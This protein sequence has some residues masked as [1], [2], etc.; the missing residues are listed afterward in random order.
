MKNFVKYMLLLPLFFTACETDYYE[1]F[2]VTDPED[3]MKIKPSGEV[4]VLEENLKDRIAL[5]FEWGDAADRG[6]GTELTCY[7]KMDIANNNFQTSFPKRELE[8]E[9]RSVSFTHEELNKLITGFWKKEAG[10]TVELEVE[11]IADVTVYPVYMKP[12]VSKTM[13]TVTSYV[14]AP[15]NLYLTGSAIKSEDPAKAV[16]LNVLS[17]NKEY[18]WKGHLDAG[19]FK[20][21]Q[22]RNEMLPS[23]NKGQDR[24]ALFYR[25]SDSDPDDLFTVDQDGIHSIY[26]N[27]EEMKIAC[28]PLPY[29]NVWMVGHATPA[30]WDIDNPILMAWDPQTPELFIYE[31]PL[32]AGEIKL[33]LAKGDWGCDYLMPVENGAGIDDNRVRFVQGGQ[34]DNKWQINESGNYRIVLNVINMTI[35]FIKL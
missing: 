6:P 8:K 3:F 16:M 18:V 1:H 29:E 10:K 9:Q 17:F 12:E 31:G 4:I 22:S 33:P 2:T 27:T 21:I 11:I 19:N 28:S 30:G 35:H 34:P 15:V 23:Y 7:F 5:T 14:I 13:V 24:T 32:S 26:V 25:T 20:F